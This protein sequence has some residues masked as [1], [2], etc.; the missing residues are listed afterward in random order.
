MDEDGIEHELLHAFAKECEERMQRAMA[1]LNECGGGAGQPECCDRLH[2][3][4]DS[5]SGAARAINLTVLERFSRV[6]ATYLRGLRNRHM[7]MDQAGRR[8]MLEEAIRFLHEHAVNLSCNPTD[9]L[10]RDLAA[11]QARFEADTD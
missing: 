10:T 4:F 2:Q 8:E 7:D 5:L 1:V 3:E 9:Q 6:L 11:L